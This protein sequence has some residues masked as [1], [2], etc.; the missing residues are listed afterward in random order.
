[1]SK[2]TLAAEYERLQAA[3]KAAKTSE[4]ELAARKAL[5]DFLERNREFI[6]KA[7]QD[8]TNQVTRKTILT[9][10]GIGLGIATLLGVGAVFAR[11]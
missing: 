1:M 5:G 9:R 3:V 11:R 4:D 8:K 10:V 7:I 2:E 6:N